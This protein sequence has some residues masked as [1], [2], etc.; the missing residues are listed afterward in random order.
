MNTGLFPDEW[1]LVELL[2]QCACLAR[3]LD[4]IDLERF[5]RNVSDLQDQVLALP[6]K[7]QLVQ[8]HDGSAPHAVPPRSEED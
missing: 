8:R 4:Q 5:C 2:A 3:E 1:R 6:A 7:R